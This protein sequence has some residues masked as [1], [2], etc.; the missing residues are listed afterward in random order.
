MIKMTQLLLAG[1]VALALSDVGLRKTLLRSRPAGHSPT[2][3]RP[4]TW[5]LRK[6]L[7]LRPCP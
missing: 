4:P 6:T 5:T 2:T 3:Y 1:A 7:P